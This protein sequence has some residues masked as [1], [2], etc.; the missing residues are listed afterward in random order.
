MSDK[1]TGWR[2]N[3]NPNEDS[4][5]D[6]AYQSQNNSN[7]NDSTLSASL[8]TAK[9]SDILSEN[10]ISTPETPRRSQISG[11]LLNLN[12]NIDE[13]NLN[14]EN[15]NMENGEERPPRNNGIGPIHQAVSNLPY[16]DGNPRMLRQFISSL[17]YL[18]D[19]YGNDNDRLILTYIPN[20]LKGKALMT[21]GGNASTYANINDFLEAVKTEFGGI[22]DLDTLRMELYQVEQDENETVSEYSTR[23]EDI[24]QR[25]LAAYEATLDPAEQ[26]QAQDPAKQRLVEDILEAFLHGLKN[27][28]EYQVAIKNPTTL[29]EASRIAE[30]LEKKQQ[31]VLGHKN[32][33]KAKKITPVK[34]KSPVFEIPVQEDP[35]D[36]FAP[37]IAENNDIALLIKLMKEWKSEANIN[38]ATTSKSV[39][40][41]KPSINEQ[42]TCN[43]CKNKGHER[44]SCQLFLRIVD[45]HMD[46]LRFLAVNE[47][48]RAE[49]I[50]Y[51]RNFFDPFNQ[52]SFT[53]IPF[54]RNFDDGYD[55]NRFS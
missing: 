23:F 51:D 20:R 34:V 32:V 31:F 46:D 54:Q 17:Q 7:I 11:Q 45:Q 37:A 49:M 2:E 39:E 6:S 5:E 3:I 38:V 27:P 8:A 22:H 15:L 19:I 53:N 43:F 16:F 47:F 33:V 42:L 55:M 30:T 12:L 36:E 40:N 28:P 21:F 24:E 9:D 44:A 48:Q 52:N 13:E 50:P 10:C 26:N 4:D 1:K 35:D 18:H 29:A 25:L 14:E 41:K